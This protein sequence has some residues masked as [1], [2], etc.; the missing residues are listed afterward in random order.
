MLGSGAVMM[1]KEDK[2]PRWRVVEL[3]DALGGATKVRELALQAGYEPLP[4]RTIQNWRMRQS[5]PADGVALLLTLGR[6]QRVTFDPWDYLD[7][8]ATK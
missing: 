2:T 5:A 7:A 4:Y 3:I 1:D 8:E 6:G